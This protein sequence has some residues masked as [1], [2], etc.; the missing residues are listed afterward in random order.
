MR[1]LRHLDVVL[2]IYYALLGL[3]TVPLLALRGSVMGALA[4]ALVGGLFCWLAVFNIRLWRAEA[5]AG[6]QT[7]TRSYVSATVEW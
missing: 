1:A 3:V 7:A 2:H 4:M 5:V 6:R